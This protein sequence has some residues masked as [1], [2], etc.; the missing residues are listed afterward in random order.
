MSAHRI[1]KDLYQDGAAMVI[2]DPGDAGTITVDRW[3]SVCPLVTAGAETRVL[4]DPAKA[5]VVLVLLGDAIT[6]SCRITSAG[7]IGDAATTSMIMSAT[8]QYAV[9]ISSKNGTTY[10]W[11][12][13]TTSCGT[14]SINSGFGSSAYPLTTATANKNFMEYRV[15]STATSGTNRGLYLRHDLAGAAGGGEAIRA[16][17]TLSAANTTAHGAHISL[18]CSATGYVTGLAAGVRG[19]LY[20]Q[21]ISP[22]NGTYYGM[23]AE[24]YFDASAT[25][26]AAAEHAILAVQANGDATAAATCKNAISFVGGAASGGGDMVSPGTSMGTVTGTI[27]V[28]VNGAVRYIPFYSHEGHA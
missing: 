9:L 11:K 5:G 19:Q 3:F 15:K 8:G 13:L 1:L 6:T 25:I 22:A 17:T 18:N 10:T 24:M 16:F 14:A 23:Q 21:G 26:A 4:P 2:P 12:V 7:G 27:R 28:L 20:V